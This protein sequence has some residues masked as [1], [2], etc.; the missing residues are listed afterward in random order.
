LIAFTRPPITLDIA[1]GGLA[2]EPTHA[3]TAARTP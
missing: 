1:D 3:K 2:A